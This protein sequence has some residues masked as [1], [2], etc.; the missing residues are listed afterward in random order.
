MYL[1]KKIKNI[2]N[3]FYL[4]IQIKYNTSLLYISSKVQITHLNNVE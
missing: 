1:Q 3:I 2:N 4:Q